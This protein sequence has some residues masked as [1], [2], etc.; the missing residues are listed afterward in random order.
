MAHHAYCLTGGSD[1]KT[2]IALNYS[3]PFF[4]PDTFREYR[5]NEWID[6]GTTVMSVVVITVNIK[7]VIF[8]G[9]FFLMTTSQVFSF[10]TGKLKTQAPNFSIM[11]GR[12]NFSI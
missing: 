11:L 3:P 9:F 10:Q 5:N 2:R 7:T 8:R 1:V 12:L 6:V 4:F